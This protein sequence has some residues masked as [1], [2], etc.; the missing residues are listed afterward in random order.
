MSK[1][2]RRTHRESK[3][4]IDLELPLDVP[5]EL[6]ERFVQDVKKKVYK[7]LT[8]YTLASGYDIKI[9]VAKKILRIAAQQ[10]IIKLYSS[11]RT[12]IYVVS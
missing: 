3:E 8:P 2:S 9:S 7:V 11:G 1:K 4:K 10:G 5:R 6:Y 12:P